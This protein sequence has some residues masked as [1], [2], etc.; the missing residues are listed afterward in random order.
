MEELQNLLMKIKVSIL[1]LKV[2]RYLTTCRLLTHHVILK[3]LAQIIQLGNGDSFKKNHIYFSKVEKDWMIHLTF[4]SILIP[5]HIETYA[6][7]KNFF[8]KEKR[9]LCQV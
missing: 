4:F 3:K 2:K 8:F 5:R 1:L 9:K 6:S 7:L